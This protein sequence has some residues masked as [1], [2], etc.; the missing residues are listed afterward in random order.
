MDGGGRSNDGNLETPPEDA[1]VS[2]ERMTVALD[3]MGW[4][5]CN[6]IPRKGGIHPRGRRD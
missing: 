1:G 6:D 2:G 3:L 4:R 5:V